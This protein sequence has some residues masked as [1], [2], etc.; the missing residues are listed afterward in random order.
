MKLYVATFVDYES[1]DPRDR[2]AHLLGVYTSLP[3][4][5]LAVKAGI[6]AWRDSHDG[7]DVVCDFDGMRAWRVFDEDN[8]VEWNI[9]ASDDVTIHGRVMRTWPTRGA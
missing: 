9:E 4:A 5:W 3:A 7:E 8:G 6:E 2:K 1:D